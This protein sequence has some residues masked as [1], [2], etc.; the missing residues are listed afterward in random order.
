MTSSGPYSEAMNF[1]HMFDMPDLRGPLPELTYC[2]G[3]ITYI[4]NERPDFSK[5]KYILNLAKLDGIYNDMQANFTVF[6][7]SDKALSHINNN[8]FVNMNVLTAR[9]IVKS[10]TLNRKI[11][12]AILSD[13]PSSWF[14]TLDPRN[15][16]LVT[17]MNDRTF[18]N[19]T[20]N[21]IHKDMQSS[22]GIIHVI[23]ELLWPEI[24]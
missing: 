11:T 21:V 12:S 1:T 17:S 19:N 4:I 8:V 14:H 18:L 22:N 16:L 10:S 7:P 9:A 15:R 6:V 3:S 2:K 13:S 24:I 20:I 23:D 5:F